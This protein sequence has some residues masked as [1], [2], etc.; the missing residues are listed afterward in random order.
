MAHPTNC[1]TLVTFTYPNEGA[2]VILKDWVDFTGAAL[3]SIMVVS[4]ACFQESPIFKRWK[5]A[6]PSIEFLFIGDPEEHPDQYYALGV[7][8]AMEQVRNEFCL[9][10]KLDV[11]PF[12]KGNDHWVDEGIAKVNSTKAFALTGSDRWP[13]TQAI[14]ARYGTTHRIS[15][16]FALY[17]PKQYLEIVETS[18]P[19]FVKKARDCKVEFK[20][21]FSL[22]SSVE[23]WLES[24]GGFNLVR[25]EDHDWSVFHIHQFDDALSRIREKYRKRIGLDP[26]LNRIDPDRK[27]PWEYHP[28]ERHYGTPRPNLIKRLR[29]R[30]GKWRKSLS[31]RK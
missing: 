29:I 31:G 21:R 28:W 9:F 26:F 3:G 25:H 22:E 19:E 15:L 14:D 16:N 17:R 7:L 11:L 10:V 24:S 5:D 6:F 20:D 30:I 4:P 27:E 18:N 23:E 1:I 8:M 12:R 13:K 2:D